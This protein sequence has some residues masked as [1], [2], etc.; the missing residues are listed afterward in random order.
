[1]RPRRQLDER[2][3]SILRPLPPAKTRVKTV[4]GLNS[5]AAGSTEH[6]LDSRSLQRDPQIGQ[7]TYD[8]YRNQVRHKVRPG[9]TGLAQVN[10]LR[11]ETKTLGKMAERVRYDLKYSRNRLPWLDVKILFRTVWIV[12]CDRHKTY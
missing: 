7:R 11:G 2:V 10:G 12:L 6:D 4:Y 3:P 8:K 9:I 1:M 5:N